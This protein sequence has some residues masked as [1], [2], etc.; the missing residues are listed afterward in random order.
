MSHAEVDVVIVGAGPAGLACASELSDLK[1]LVLERASRCGGRIETIDLAAQRVDMG[2][3]FAVDPGVAPQGLATHPG[4]LVQE[5]AVTAVCDSDGIHFGA[6]PLDCIAASTIDNETRRQIDHFARSDQDAAALQGSHAYQLLNA[7]L[8][9]VHPG[10]LAEYDS[11]HQRDGLYT[12]YPDHWEQGNQ[13]LTDSLLKQSNAELRLNA[14]VMQISERADGLE[15]AFRS[16]NEPGRISCRAA[17]IATTADVA[18]SLLEHPDPQLRQ[19]LSC[20]RYGSYIVVALAG[21]ASPALAEFRS[22]LPA[23]GSP[24]VVMQQRSFGR[25][26][27]VLL[28][29]Y[30]SA[31]FAALESKTEAELVTMSKLQLAALGIPAA[32]LDPLTESAVRRWKNAATILTSDYRRGREFAGKA[33]SRAVFL[34]GDYTC[35]EPAVGYGIADAVASGIDTARKVRV[36]LNG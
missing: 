36:A 23:D 35:R 4:R 10:E 2:A 27:A 11:G 1:V 29:Y 8:H 3:C 18:S 16:D 32:A 19:W 14:E 6:T 13:V 7:Q 20:T 31:D 22:L 17:V 28:C 33:G 5:R 34:A 21:A 30:C 24:A 25:D 15:V 26:L 12:W 9:Q